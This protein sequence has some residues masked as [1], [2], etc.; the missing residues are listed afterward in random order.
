ML[1]K[2]ILGVLFITGSLVSSV[3]SAEECIFNEDQIQ[4][5]KYSYERGK[6]HGYEWTL[7]AISWQESGAG[8][9][10]KN[11]TSDSYGPYGN[12]LRTVE[13]RLKMEDSIEGL[14][15]IPL[16]REQTIFLLKNDWEFSSHFAIVEL[17]NWEKVHKGNKQKAIA[18][19]FGG[20]TP[21][22]KAA[23]NYLKK[24]NKKI[25][26]LK[27]SGCGIDA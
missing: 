27:N 25:A 2:L 14:S 4:V 26:Y 18:S 6:E 9:K 12:L 20:Y 17:Q 10:L 7:A 23:Q 24:L 22:T 5:L 16:N 21:S 15:K 11:P 3:S 8:Q 1:K 19:Y 13:K